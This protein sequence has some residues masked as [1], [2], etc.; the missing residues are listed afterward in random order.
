MDPVLMQ[1]EN[2][3][4]GGTITSTPKDR[5]P[6]SLWSSWLVNFLKSTRDSYRMWSKVVKSFIIFWGGFALL[7]AR[8]MLK[9]TVTL[10]SRQV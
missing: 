1:E 8:V 3:I 6:C 2:P 7:L 9:N 4:R 10:V 5:I